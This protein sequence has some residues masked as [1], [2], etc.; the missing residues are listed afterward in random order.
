MLVPGYWRLRRHL[1]R[2]PDGGCLGP[3]SDENE[4]ANCVVVA[5]D[6]DL[7]V[8]LVARVDDNHHHPRDGE[9]IVA[10]QHPAVKVQLHLAVFLL[11]FREVCN[12]LPVD[13][14]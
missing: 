8:N 1:R 14:P 3:A 9:A 13:E 4:F 6:F 11:V 5:R 2:C 10:L 7:C 12:V